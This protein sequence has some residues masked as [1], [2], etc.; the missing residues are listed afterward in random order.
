VRKDGQALGC[1]T[2]APGLR[3]RLIARP[4]GYSIRLTAR[5]NA[6]LAGVLGKP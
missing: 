6:I 1:A 2:L 3:S 4:E 5:G